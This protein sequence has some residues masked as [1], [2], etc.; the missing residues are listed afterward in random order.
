MAYAQLTYREVCATSKTVF[1]RSRRSSTTGG[2]GSRS[3]DPRWPTPKSREPE[4]GG[5][6][7][8]TAVTWTSSDGMPSIRRT[9]S[10]SLEPSP[11]CVHFQVE[12]SG[13]FHME[14]SRSNRRN[15]QEYLQTIPCDRTAA[16]PSGSIVAEARRALAR[17]DELVARIPWRYLVEPR[18]N[19]NLPWHLHMRL[20]T[21]EIYFDWQVSSILPRKAGE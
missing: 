19:E 14:P 1:W 6:T 10:S 2:F 20:H 5:S 18:R 15:S 9:H 17:R 8:W 21:V 13:G 12:S 4:A 3:S 11:A 16:A 7:S